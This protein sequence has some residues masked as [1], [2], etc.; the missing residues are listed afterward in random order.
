MRIRLQAPPSRLVAIAATAALL[1]ACGSNEPASPFAPTDPAGRLFEPGHVVEVAV[2]IS[3]GDWDTLRRQ[4]RTWWDVAAA[5]DKACLVQPF[6]KPF[7]WFTASITV[8]GVRRDRVAVRKKGFIGSLNE[9][10]PALKVRFDRYVEGQT[11]SGLKRLTLNNAVQD[12]TWLKQCLAYRVF[13]K[14]GLPVPYCNFAHLTVNGRDLG[15]YVHLESQDRRWVRRYFEK[16]EGDLWEGEISDFREGWVDT[17]EK[18]GDV[19][20]D[21]Q[22][23]V[24]RS[25]LAEVAA[26]VAPGLPGAQVRSRLEEL[27]DLDGFMRFWAAEKVLEH[28]DGYANNANNFFLYR[29]PATS[30]FVFAPAGTD[31]ITVPDPFSSTKPP[32]SVYAAGALSNRLY[33][34]GETRQLYA[35]KIRDVLDRAFDEVDLLSE[36]DRMQ[37]LVAPIVARSGGEAASAQAKA[38]DELRAWVRG[39]RAVLLKDLAGGPPEWQQPLKQSICVDLAGEIEGAFGTAF[40]TNRE[41]DAFRTGNGALAGVYRRAT[42]SVR[43][44]GSQAGYDKNA[45]ADPWPVVDITAEA[46]DG[47][48]YT[49]WIGVNPA[50]FQAGASGP[51]DGTFA[52]GGIGNWNPRTSQWTY[53]GGFVDGW[54][55][56]DRASLATGG[57]VSGR[58]R[59]RVIQW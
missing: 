58:F 23:R 6:P 22:T 32:V 39:R 20:D 16:D 44:V 43:R 18:K 51:F 31:Q 46:A 4:T 45:Q 26:A 8:D 19:E 59:A 17:F 3:P 48:Y 28:W 10:R 36:I 41:P 21:D 37:A 5:D 50:R 29:D 40:G 7:D 2:E 24:D 25:S 9:E 30:K 38:V 15:L 34:I 49:L 12:P 56:I 11:L 27:V 52:W 55:E 57:P 42:I 35:T 54:V 14:T 53:L 33:G 47:T 13:E 1:A